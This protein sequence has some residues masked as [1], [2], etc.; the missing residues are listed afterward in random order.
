[1]RTSWRA[2]ERAHDRGR[3]LAHERC[4]A[5]Q[6]LNTKVVLHTAYGVNHILMSEPLADDHRWKKRSV[7]QQLR[8]MPS[9]PVDGDEDECETYQ[10][11]TSTVGAGDAVHHEA[12][13]ESSSTCR[14]GGEHMGDTVTG[15]DTGVPETHPLM[16]PHLNVHQRSS[17]F[18]KDTS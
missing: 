8:W 12:Y 10:V 7:R 13:A 1:L 18:K 4:H 9:A 6:Q 5:R 14:T 3:K 15:I 16:H 2:A 17:N 11:R